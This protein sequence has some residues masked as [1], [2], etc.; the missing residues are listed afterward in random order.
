V[1]QHIWWPVFAF[2][3]LN[4]SRSMLV[5]HVVVPISTDIDRHSTLPFKIRHDEMRHHRRAN[6]IQ[7]SRSHPRFGPESPP[8][9]ARIRNRFLLRQTSM[10][11]MWSTP[12]TVEEEKGDFLFFHA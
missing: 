10:Y 12:P 11:W 9:L 4:T 1:L 3:I 7:G 2:V 8:S 6:H 5:A